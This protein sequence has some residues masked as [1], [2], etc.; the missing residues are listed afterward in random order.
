M[1][2]AYD[3]AVALVTQLAARGG[4]PSAVLAQF[5]AQLVAGVAESDL[6]ALVVALQAA[7]DAL[8]QM[9]ETKE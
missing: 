5:N 7:L 1:S 6:P 8:P 9:L 4:N 3:Q 2:D